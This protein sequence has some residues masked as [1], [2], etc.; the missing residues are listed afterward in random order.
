MTDAQLHAAPGLGRISLAE[1]KR[2]R[3]QF[4]NDR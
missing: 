3:S 4:I 2:Y 1:I